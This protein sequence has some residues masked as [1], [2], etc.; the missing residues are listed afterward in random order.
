MERAIELTSTNAARRFGLPGK[1][2][3]GVGADADLVVLDEGERTVRADEVLSAVDYSPYEG[4]TLQ[5]W[6]YV[7]MCSGR[8]VY[9]E[10]KLVQDDFR[11]TILNARA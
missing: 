6:P 9:Q 3:I 1:G 11:G 2:W 7:T 5:A 10:G 4:Y 8:V